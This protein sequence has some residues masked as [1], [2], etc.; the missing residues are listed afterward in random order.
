[1]IKG[2]SSSAFKRLLHYLIIKSVADVLFIGLIA[3]GFYYTAFNPNFQGA[4]DDAGP[5]WIRGWVVDQ[6]AKGKPVEVQL[7]IDGKFADSRLADY[8]RPEIVAAGVADREQHGFLF[9]TPPLP[10]G[11]HEARVY[12]MHASNGG[13]LRT[14]QIIGVPRRFKMYA[15]SAEPFYR[16]WVDEANQQI[17]RG[18]VVSRDVPEERAEVHLYI[19]GRFIEKRV[20]DYPRPELLNGKLLLD[21]KHGFLFFTPQLAQG[22][23]EARVY[24]SRATGSDGSRQLLL[25]GR[26]LQFRV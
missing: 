9:Y 8:P 19:D 10:E 12:A 24:V 1:M 18:W 16:G 7:F 4:L 17:V 21:E 23:H 13:R 20:A 26:P 15:N 11:E 6:S 14:M 22:E 5:E 25:I 2:N 3:V